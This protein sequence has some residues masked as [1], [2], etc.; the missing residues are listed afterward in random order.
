MKKLFFLFVLPLLGWA[1]SA[2]Q[3]DTVRVTAGAHQVTE[4]QLNKGLVT[5]GVGALNGQ[6]A[7]VTIS[8]GSNRAA[9]LSHSCDRCFSSRL[10]LI[11][12]KGE[13]V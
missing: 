3:A 11:F 4:D 8:S 13:G 12:R 7:G 10:S 6:T 1:A 2:Q 5:S 9:M